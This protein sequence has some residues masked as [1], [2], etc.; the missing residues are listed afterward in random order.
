MFDMVLLLW[1]SW[2][3]NQGRLD[4]PYF[5]FNFGLYT[6]THTEGCFVKMAQQSPAKWTEI[7]QNPKVEMWGH[8]DGTTLIHYEDSTY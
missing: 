4:L 7:N 3:F 6:R 8:E 5:V 2:T 1:Y